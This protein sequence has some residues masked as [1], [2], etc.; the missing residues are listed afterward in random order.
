MCIRDRDRSERTFLEIHILKSL[1]HPNII[2]LKGY[3]MDDENIYLILEY[4]SGNNASKMFKT[5]LP[6][7]IQVKHIIKQLVEAVKFCHEKGIIHRD[8]KLEN[9]MIDE[10]YNIKLI[11][12]GLSVIKE[13]EFDIF[14]DRLGTQRYTCLLYTSPS[15]RDRS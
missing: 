6:S 11:D 14:K 3:F 4:I 13:T 7:K 10:K 1:K 9:I 12:F 2:Q 8:I 5:Q 15:P